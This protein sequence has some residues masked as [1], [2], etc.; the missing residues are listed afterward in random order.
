MNK[1]LVISALFDWNKIYR[2][3]STK[4]SIRAVHKDYESHE[5]VFYPKNIETSGLAEIYFDS[6]SR[7]KSHIHQVN[8]HMGIWECLVR[9]PL[10]NDVPGGAFR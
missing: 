9:N 10:F 6:L 8:V 4:E 2:V 1:I 7:N 5:S 3:M